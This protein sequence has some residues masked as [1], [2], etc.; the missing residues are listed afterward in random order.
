MFVMRHI[1]QKKK[2]NISSQQFVD[3]CSTKLALWGKPGML[4]H[5]DIGQLLIILA[6]T[7][8]HRKSVVFSCHLC[9]SCIFNS[10]S[11]GHLLAKVTLSLIHGNG[12]IFTVISL[13]KF[14]HWEMIVKLNSEE[15]LSKCLRYKV[16]VNIQDL[17]DIQVFQYHHRRMITYSLQIET[18]FAPTPACQFCEHMRANQAAVR[19]SGP[20]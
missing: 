13:P 20:L 10:L 12:S 17:V 11:F 4:R 6:M 14:P 5:I 1:I 7:H 16:H 3:N 8:T 19:E 2:K 18:Q 15:Q 9:F